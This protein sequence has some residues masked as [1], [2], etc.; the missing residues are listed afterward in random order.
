MTARTWTEGDPKPP[1]H[2][3][4]V[5]DEEG[6][7]WAHGYVCGSD[8]GEDDAA[9]PYWHQHL[10]TRLTSGGVLGGSIGNTWDDIWGSLPEGSTLREA[11]D[12]E[13]LTWVER[14]TS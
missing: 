3:R 6:V 13:R 11:T 8:E 2:V 5:V 10:I 7:T 4:A 14:W 1:I 9:S 12:L